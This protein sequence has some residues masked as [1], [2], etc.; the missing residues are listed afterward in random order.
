[1]GINY[2][3]VDD[4]TRM[5]QVVK[6][7]TS[8]LGT[9]WTLA[10]NGNHGF[11]IKSVSHLTGVSQTLPLEKDEKLRNMLDAH[12]TLS[13]RTLYEEHVK[14]TLHISQATF[15]RRVQEVRMRSTPP[16]VPPTPPA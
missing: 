4:T 5:M 9:Q 6:S 10:F 14:P 1:M 11:N 15:Y 2:V 12:P 16:E 8:N 3:K 13:L 7:R